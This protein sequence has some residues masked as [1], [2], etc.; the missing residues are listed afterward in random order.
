[1]KEVEMKNKKEF[2]ITELH[3][4]DDGLEDTVDY[5]GPFTLSKCRRVLERMFKNPGAM[6]NP[7]S[8][9]IRGPEREVEAVG[10]DHTYK[11]P[12]YSNKEKDSD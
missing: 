7:Y 1:M 2:Y 6:V 3:M 4:G 9:S 8:F 12:W 11:S 10:G 5:G